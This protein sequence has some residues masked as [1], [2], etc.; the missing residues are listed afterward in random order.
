MN[1][2]SFRAYFIRIIK[3]RKF[4]IKIIQDKNIKLDYKKKQEQNKFF[5]LRKNF[6]TK[7]HLKINNFVKVFLERSEKLAKEKLKLLKSPL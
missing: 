5:I 7:S 6:E 2:L 1:E 3:R 4:L